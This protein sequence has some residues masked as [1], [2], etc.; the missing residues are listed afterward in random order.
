MLNDVVIPFVAIEQNTTIDE[1]PIN[2]DCEL[3]FVSGSGSRKERNLKVKNKE[4]ERLFN[5]AMSLPKKKQTKRDP[6]KEAALKR[7]DKNRVLQAEQTTDEAV[8]QCTELQAFGTLLSR[9]H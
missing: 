7:A 3:E 9:L 2:E 4:E 8:D 5:K 6:V 1:C